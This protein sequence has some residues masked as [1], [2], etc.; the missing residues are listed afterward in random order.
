[1]TLAPLEDGD[2]VAV[3]AMG[4]SR[5]AANALVAVLSTAGHRAVGLTAS[6]VLIGPPGFQPGDHYVIVSESGRSPEPIEAARRLT[7]GRRIGVSNFPAAQIGEVVDGCIDLGGIVDS[8]V[9]TVG[10]TGTLLAFGHLAERWGVP[11]ATAGLGEI[12]SLIAEHERSFRPAMNTVGLLLGRADSVDVVGSG[13]SFAT[14]TEFALMVREALRTPSTAYDTYEYLHGPMESVGRG[15]A[16]VVFG[17][18]RELA[19]PGPLLDAG[20]PVVLVTTRGGAE[21]PHAEHPLLTVVELRRG[22]TGFARAVVEIV[23]AQRLVQAAAEH[24]PFSIEEFRFTGL[25]TKLN[26]L[27]RRD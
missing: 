14:A 3:I 18:G 10:Y 12:E 9:Y 8:P 23:F 4:A 5:N 22:L 24:K 27:P 20:V 26:E 2:T 19:V 15:T 1:M 21:V 13:V 16:V 25:G 17:D 7:P 6:E 11:D